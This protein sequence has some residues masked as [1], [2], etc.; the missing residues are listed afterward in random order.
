MLPLFREAINRSRSPV[1]LRVAAYVVS[2][3]I[4]CA[5][6]AAAEEGPKFTAA[7]R[8]FWSFR[9]LGRSSVPEMFDASS[10]TPID[11]FL[12]AKLAGEGLAF[13]PP[14]D[15][16]TLI[17]RLSF[18]LLGLPPSPEESQDF[19]SDRRADAYERLVERLLASPHY[20]ERWGRHW[21]DVAGYSDSNGYHRADT[22][23][24]LAWRYRDYVIRSF[25]DDKPHDRFWLEQLAGDELA[26][27]AQSDEYLP[28]RFE[29]LVATHFL[30]NGP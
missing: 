30:R 21:L 9:R 6:P 14:A 15:R 27:P 18:D 4:I 16:A 19:V 11:R 23:R 3:L 17:R 12:L 25:N 13:S 2:S 29:L 20:G 24:P 26:G 7:E 5:A 28:E 22:L 8:D 10:D 1:R